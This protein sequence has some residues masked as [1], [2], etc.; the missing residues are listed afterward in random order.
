MSIA[1]WFRYITARRR[2]QRSERM[3]VMPITQSAKEVRIVAFDMSNGAMNII[4]GRPMAMGIFSLLAAAVVAVALIYALPALAQEPNAGPLGGFT[5]VDASDQTEL[6][7]LTDSGSVELADPDGGSYGIRA[8]IAEGETVGSVRLELSGAK[9]V[10]PKT[11]NLAPYSLYGDHRSGAARHL[12]GESLPAG[13]Y[14]LTA[15][16]YSERQ[17]GGDELGTLEVSFT[18]TKANSAP[19][20]GSATYSFSIADDAATGAAV[21]SVSATDAD[22]DGLTYSIE[23][24]NGDGK[25]AMDGSSGAIT[26][27]G[28]L[29]H[30]ATASYTLTVQADD[31]NGGTATATVNVSVTD[32]AESTTG[33][34]TG[35]MLVD[36]SDQTELATLTAGARVELADPDGGSYAVRA[37]VDANANIGSVRLALSGAKTVSRTES[38]APY[39]LYGD[40]GA[41]ALDGA[42]LPAGSYTMTATA[43]AESN[44]GGD[45]LGSLEVSFTVTQANRAPEF[46]SSTYNFS[47]AEDA[48]AGT[49][50]GS[51]SASDEDSDGL[52]YSIESGNGTAS[53]PSTAAAEPSPRRERWTMLQRRPT[54]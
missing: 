16:A 40:G 6:A 25:F 52:T 42:S 9:S 49:A 22:D 41:D 45:E 38:V 46:A 11:E 39:S 35:F 8:D 23:S 53:S 48:A 54:R 28:A 24:G 17:L 43:Y 21:G 36:A 37:D 44:L 19:E 3:T 5:L 27:A 14:T 12:D 29:D 51:V 15:T 10:G 20:F 31:G 26:V 33:P 30:A 2:R 32:V 7:T 47:V 13:S 34:L 4:S 18:V 1:L 50:V